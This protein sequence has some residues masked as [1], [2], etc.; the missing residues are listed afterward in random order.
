M[1]LIWCHHRTYLMQFSF[2]YSFEK[3]CYVVKCA[4][5]WF[6][7][8]GK[9][10]IHIGLTPI[11][12][13]AT[14]RLLRKLSTIPTNFWR[15]GPDP[16]TTM[17][18][19]W[20]CTCDACVCDIQV[21][22]TLLGK[23]DHGC[24]THFSSDPGR[25]VF[26]WHCFSLISDTEYR[27]RYPGHNWIHIYQPLQLWVNMPQGLSQLVSRQLESRRRK[28]LKCTGTCHIYTAISNVPHSCMSV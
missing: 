10:L 21:I 20:Y 17:C 19:L 11:W 23:M 7:Q 22:A 12:L 8:F 26:G 5:A 28:T 24:I 14:D 6:N 15:L 18:T 2:T 13:Q 27:C 3:F 1:V 4:Q 9:F 25:L 16:D